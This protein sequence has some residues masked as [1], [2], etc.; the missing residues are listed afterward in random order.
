MSDNI[1]NYVEKLFEDAPK[2]RKA[3]ELKEEMIAN[4]TEKLNY[5]TEAGK[6]EDEA[7]NIVVSGIGDISEL[8]E[9]LKEYSGYEPLQYQL[10]RKKNALIVSVSVM[11]Y[12]LSIVVLILSSEMLQLPG[13]ISVSFMFII[14]GAAT[15]M[16]IYN[17]MS[18]PKYL[19]RDETMVEEFKEWKASQNKDKQIR[20]S[21]SSAMWT[22]TV[23]IYLIISF[24][25]GIWDISW[26]IFI[27]AAAVEQIIKAFFEIKR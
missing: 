9:S 20:R 5:L 22:L 12:I 17:S 19:K 23:A 25:F 24:A 15:G 13:S 1:R 21:I 27:I 6:G 4:L 2:T 3:T 7:F 10:Q 16:L 8:F 26:I 11:L 14:A 18:Q